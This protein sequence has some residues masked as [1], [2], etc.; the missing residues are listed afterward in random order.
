M[1]DG[2]IK[3]D[4]TSRLIKANLP[5]TYEQLRTM[6]AAGALPADILFNAAGWDVLPDF[7][8]KKNLLTDE[9]AALFGLGGDSVPDEVLRLLKKAVDDHA[10]EISHRPLIETGSYTGTGTYGE[11]G[12]NKLTFDFAPKFIAVA[13]PLSGNGAN[14]DYAFIVAGYSG[15]SVTG[16]I[17][18]G[19]NSQVAMLKSTVSGTTVSWFNGNNA[20]WQA[21]QNGWIYNYVAVG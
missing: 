15:M 6:A 16:S 17:W 5:A 14:I 7:L 1:K 13:S 20:L 2:V 12:A 19:A 10:L 4:G 18:N 21:N 3:N 9:T 11:T 8:N